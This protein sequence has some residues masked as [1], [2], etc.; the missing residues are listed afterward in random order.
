L[1]K[2]VGRRRA[3]GPVRLTVDHSFISQQENELSGQV[4]TTSLGSMGTG[5]CASSRSTL[6]PSPR[7]CNTQ[8]ACMQASCECQ[9]PMQCLKFSRLGLIHFQPNSENS[10]RTRFPRV[11]FTTRNR[12]LSHASGASLVIAQPNCSRHA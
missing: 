7:A 4:P 5:A 1:L 10:A 6:Q 2:W 11:S 12:K 8:S 9:T 3:S